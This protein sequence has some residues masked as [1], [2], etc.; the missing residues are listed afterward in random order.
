MARRSPHPGCMDDR[1]G[2]LA[3]R[4]LDSAVGG[5]AATAG[6]ALESDRLSPDDHRSWRPPREPWV[7]AQTWE[8]LVFA[9]WPV[10]PA[11]LR[12][13][14]PAGL[15]L[16]TFDGAAW[17]GITP[18]RV[19]QLRLRGLPAIPGVSDFRELNVRTYVTVDDKP[20]VFFF[21]LDASS[22]LAVQGARLWYRL[23]YHLASAT[24]DARNGRVRFTS[25]RLEGAPSEARFTIEYR[26]VG[27]VEHAERG[28]LPW[29]LTERYCL[30]TVAGDGEIERAEIHHAPWPLQPVEGTI[31]ENTMVERLGLRLTE[32]P[33][34][35]H[36]SATLDVSVWRPRAV[37]RRP[38]RR[39]RAAA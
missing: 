16:D 36:Y 31:H 10:A 25:R 32:P 30:Y 38:R 27:P 7:M 35:L 12:R 15:D 18:F 5:F 9:H 20:G 14:V 23:P 4:L 37:R 8:H 1:L 39:G 19:R 24:L 2:V 26:P 34:L 33:A 21:S 13:L 3:R 11:E 28:S 22:A 17:L 29:W 6:R